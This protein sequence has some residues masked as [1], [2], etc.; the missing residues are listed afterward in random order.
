MT[1]FKK[2]LVK[3]LSVLNN[4]TDYF[5]IVKTESEIDNIRQAVYIADSILEKVIPQVKPGVKEITIKEM[6]E[7]EVKKSKASKVAFDTIVATGAN[8]AFPH[9]LSGERVIGK[10]DIVFIDFGV[11]Y[12][13]YHSDITRT[14]L[15]NPKDEKAVSLYRLVYEAQKKALEM[16]KPGVEIKALDVAAR[17]YIAEHDFGDNFVHGLGHGVGLKIHEKPF[18]NQRAKGKLKKNMVITIEPGVY[19]PGYGGVRIEDTVLVTR[20]GYQLLTQTPKEIYW[21]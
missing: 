3:T 20:D 7:A 6:L 10:N 2:L 14:I 12:K 11:V 9:A 8:C 13:G 4:L 1:I 17:G 19:L 15:M 16:I 21:K 5:C 18:V